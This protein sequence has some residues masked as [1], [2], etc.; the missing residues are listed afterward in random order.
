[1]CLAKNELKLNLPNLELLLDGGFQPF[2]L[3]K[4][5]AG[6]VW[7]VPSPGDWD[8]VTF[9]TSTL[10]N[11][12]DLSVVTRLD[13]SMTFFTRL[14][15]EAYVM[16]HYGTPGG[17]LRFELD[18]PESLEGLDLGIPLS[19]IPKPVIDWGINLRLA[20]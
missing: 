11:L 2:Y 19:R 14:R 12:S 16:G 10:A 15:V 8:D 13:V 18:V 9:T 4:H 17:E 6:F 20:I 5:Y 1:M 3:G 7:S